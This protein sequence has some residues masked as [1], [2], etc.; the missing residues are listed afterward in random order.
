[1]KK[2]LPAIMVLLM[3]G[4][5]FALTDLSAGIYGGINTPIIQ[6]DAKTGTGFGFKVK[7]APTPLLGAAAFFESR[8]F[9]DPQVK[10]LEGT[11]QERT[12]KTD[13]GK[14]TVLG[15]EGL[16]G[17]TGGGIGPHFYWMVGLSNYKWTRTGY[18]NFSKVGYHTGPV[19]EIVL[20]GG[21]GIGGMAKFE[22]IPTTNNAS[23]KNALVF[24][25]VNYHFGIL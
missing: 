10:I 3:A 1:M 19:L 22:V 16:I 2:I 14:V 8:T 5:A 17:A 9:G 23:R 24:V 11:P 15:L 4:S 21:I 12:V 13:G 6:Q 18:S 7:F 25:G 20:P